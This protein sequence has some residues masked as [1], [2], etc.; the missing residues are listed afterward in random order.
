MKPGIPERICGT[1]RLVSATAVDRDGQPMPPP[2][3]PS[4]MG[5]L[6]LSPAGRMMVVICDGRTSIP[7]GEKRGYSSYCGNFRI[8]GDSLMTRVDAAALAERIG[9]QQVRAFAFRNGHL[10]LVP[11]RRPNG[12]Q[13]E[14]VWQRDGP[15]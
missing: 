7:E 5:R 11:P 1:W 2:Y 13:R 10:V 6:I 15:A 3:G 8:E 14:L 12:E 4:P 9:G